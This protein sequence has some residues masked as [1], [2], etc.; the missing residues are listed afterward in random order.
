MRD[1]DKEPE[2][3]HGLEQARRQDQSGIPIVVGLA[4]VERECWLISG[5]EPLNQDETIRLEAERQRL[6]FDPCLRS[7][8]LTA[9]KDDT[10]TRSPKRVLRALSEGSI[11]REH[12][13]TW[14]TSLNVLQARGE[15]N[16]LTKYLSEIR[17]KLGPLISG[18]ARK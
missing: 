2:R 1:Q 15:E 3:R 14:V 10:A 17:D 16:G 8:E 18:V 4:I 6:G 9:C 13:C 5:F 11:D 12:H 7:H